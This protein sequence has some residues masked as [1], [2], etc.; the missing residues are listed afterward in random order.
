[1]HAAGGADDVP[2]DNLLDVAAESDFVGPIVDNTK[3]VSN[4][5][6]GRRLGDEWNSED[7]KQQ[8]GQQPR[9]HC[10]AYGF[11]QS[12]TPHWICSLKLDTNLRFLLPKLVSR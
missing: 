12:S 10:Y 3:A 2:G 1:M 6:F 11:L 4:V 5:G 9:D 8:A 7:R